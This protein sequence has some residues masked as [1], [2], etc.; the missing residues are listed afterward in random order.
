[1]GGRAPDMYIHSSAPI[2]TAVPNKITLKLV[3]GTPSEDQTSDQTISYL[4]LG[5]L[6][7]MA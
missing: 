1:M 4:H 7:I 5:E 2:V 6:A 3:P